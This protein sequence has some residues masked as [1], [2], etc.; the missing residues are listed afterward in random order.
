MR[1]LNS[2]HLT[3]S[4]GLMR[5]IASTDLPMS[6][7]SSSVPPLGSGTVSHGSGS[8]SLQIPHAE[9]L[10]HARRYPSNVRGCI[11]VLVLLHHEHALAGAREV[12]RGDEAVRAGANDDRVVARGRSRAVLQDAH[13]RQ[14]SGGAHDPA[15]GMRAG[16]A[17]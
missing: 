7:D 15:T 14:P 6:R 10:N 3:A 9:L 4:A 16:A 11:R 1:A 17:W 12:V 13:R 5:R 2:G 8:S